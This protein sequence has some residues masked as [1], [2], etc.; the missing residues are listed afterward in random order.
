PRFS[1]TVILLIR[2][3]K[4]GAFGIT[5]NRPVG[6]LPLVRLLE[7]SGEKDLPKAGNV[8]IFAGG[9]VEQQMGFVVHSTDYQREETI[10][11]NGELAATTSA[12]TLRDMARGKG[13]RKTLVVFGYA[14]WGRGQLEAE[15][16]RHDW[17]I[18][19]ADA[20]L[21]FDTPRERVWD[22][23]MARR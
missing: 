6:E 10:A 19:T 11:I 8:R 13:P 5:L 12:E 23:A 9:P 18:A 4:D 22:E 16:A 7:G 17:L 3:G 1:R 2:H 14:G 15:L 21:V 20:A